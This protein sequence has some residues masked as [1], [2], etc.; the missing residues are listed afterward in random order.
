MCVALPESILAQLSALDGGPAERAAQ[1]SFSGIPV[2]S[3][4]RRPSIDAHGDRWGQFCQGY[5]AKRPMLPSPRFT[6]GPAMRSA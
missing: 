2:L 6:C 1:T 3:L 5:S 4:G